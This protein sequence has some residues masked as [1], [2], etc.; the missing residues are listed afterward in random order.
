[1][2]KI[3]EFL[4]S[5]ASR[6]HVYELCTLIGIEGLIYRIFYHDLVKKS[7]EF[8]DENSSRIKNNCLLLSDEKS[9]QVYK[10]AIKYRIKRYRHDHPQFNPDDQY[11]PE[12]IITLS[13]NEV[14]VDCGAYSGDTLDDFLRIES[15]TVGG[16]EYKYVA[17]E[18]EKGLYNELVSKC[19][20]NWFVAYQCGVWKNS[21][22]LKFLSGDMAVA[23]EAKNNYARDEGNYIEVEV[24][25]IDEVAECRD[26]T[27]IKMDIEGSEMEAL[28]GAEKVIKR[29]KPKLAICIYHSDEDMLRIIEY[30]HSIVPEYKLY[31]RHHSL[32]VVET[33]LYAVL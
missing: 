8:F 25:S 21:G 11:F 12:D 5:V 18:P 7:K 23:A 17:F 22:I 30:V 16:G 6:F 14:F 28:L 31:V 29:N 27:F 33:V 19:S 20:D 13:A 10:K 1:M 4:A 24:K 9:I 32:Y 3:V 26:A 15:Q 2:N